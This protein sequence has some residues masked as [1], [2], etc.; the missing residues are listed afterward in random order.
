MNLKMMLSTNRI[1]RVPQ[2][3]DP[4]IGNVNGDSS[5]S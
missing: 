1:V 2:K 3:T 4:E 5:M